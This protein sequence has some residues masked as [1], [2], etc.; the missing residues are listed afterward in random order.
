MGDI[1]LSLANPDGMNRKFAVK[2]G[3]QAHYL[4]SGLSAFQTV[5]SLT[6]PRSLAAKWAP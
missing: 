4:P 1:T 5:H 3:G 2:P 6:A